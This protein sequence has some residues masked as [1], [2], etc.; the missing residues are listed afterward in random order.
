MST[1]RLDKSLPVLARLT[2]LLLAVPVTLSM[3]NGNPLAFAAGY[4]LLR[5]AKAA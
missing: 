3:L 4:A 1:R 5:F 2:A